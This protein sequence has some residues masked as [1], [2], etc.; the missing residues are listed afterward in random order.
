M[1]RCVV[2]LSYMQNDKL[3]QGGVG[4]YILSSTI[5]IVSPLLCVFSA[6]YRFM[7]SCL[8]QCS[9]FSISQRKKYQHHPDNDSGV[10]PS[11]FT[12][13]KSTTFSEVSYNCLYASQSV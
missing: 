13:T 3:P 6:F 2:L 10:G 1:L 11:I 5:F 12:D 4:M 9:W 7:V 8:S